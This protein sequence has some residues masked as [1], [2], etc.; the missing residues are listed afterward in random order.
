MACRCS[1]RKQV[2][3]AIVLLALCGLPSEAAELATGVPQ[4]SADRS[5]PFEAVSADPDSLRWRS[6]LDRLTA[7]PAGVDWISFQDSQPVQPQVQQPVTLPAPQTPAQ[8]ATTNRIFAGGAPQSNLVSQS[9]PVSRRTAADSILGIESNARS[10]TDAGDLLGKSSRGRGIATQKRNPIITDPRMRGSRVGQLAASGSHWVPARVDMDTILSKVD[11]RILSDVVVIKGP[12]ASRYGPGFEF[13]DFEIVPSP[14]SASGPEVGGSTSLDYQSNGEHWYGRQS[15]SFADE[16]FGIRFGYGHRT[17]S[18]YESG[19]GAGIPSS[20]KSRDMNLVAGWNVDD[21][22][23]AEFYLIHQDQ[24]DVE[25]AGQIFDID[26]SVTRAFGAT[27]TDETVSWAEQFQLEAWL[28]ETQLEGNAQSAGKR[29]TFPILNTLNFAG[30]TDVESLSTGARAEARWDFDR[31][32][33]L[34]AGV[35]VRIVRQEVDEFSFE[36][37]GGQ[38]SFD[39]NSPVP[40]S[41]SSNPGLFVELQDTSID[42]LT[43]TSGARVDIVSNEMLADAQ[44]LAALGTRDP[45]ASLAEILGTGDF[46][47]SF[48]LWSA[49]I[50]GEFQADDNWAIQFAAG[51]GQRAPSLTEMY[52]A[53]SFMFLLQSGLN[54]VTGDSRL[55]PERRWQIDLGTTF[56]NDRLHLGIN[57]YHA[58][59][60]DRITFENNGVAG[61]PSGQIE[62][63][64]LKYVNT[65]RATIYGFD[66]DAEFDLNDWVSAFGSVSY[67]NGTDETRNGD[68]ATVQTNGGG[69]PSVRVSGATRGSSLNGNRTNATGGGVDV[70]QESLPGIPPLESRLGVRLKGETQG[71]VWNVELA[72]RILNAQNRVASTLGETATP[73]FS[74]WDL[75]SYWELNNNITLVAGVENFTDKDYREHFDFRSPGGLSLRQP[76]ANFY[77]GSQIVY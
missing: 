39:G 22:Q 59:V 77:F 52:A 32:R 12:Y 74:T 67:V 7:P 36:Q 9:R 38:L 28:N 5:P 69:A 61:G 1:F 13:L 4:R 37:L 65:D 49:F 62:R 60:H 56:D 40:R 18:D 33:S 31:D 47:Q 72:T 29:R 73:G 76:G 50:N 66:A 3:S 34:S 41:V 46:D 14:R 25:L 30:T 15:F 21:G 43:L 58:W 17:G 23:T 57:G 42:G 71:V 6:N 35:D 10:T 70:P 55:N 26:S 63:Y 75:R 68:F 19:G 2:T 24:S 54:T 20:Y 45:E 51:H 8:L 11:S 64:D 48:G 44:Q 16:D 27:W 53:E